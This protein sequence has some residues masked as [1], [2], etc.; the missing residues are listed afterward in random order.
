MVIFSLSWL[1]HSQVEDFQIMVESVR[2]NT[3]ILPFIFFLYIND[4]QHRTICN[5]VVIFDYDSVGFTVDTGIGGPEVVYY[6]IYLIGLEDTTYVG[7][8]SA[9]L[10]D[11]RFKVIV[12][13][14][15]GNTA[16]IYIRKRQL[17]IKKQMEIIVL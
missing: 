17:K 1:S 14:G 2:Y 4:G 12:L 6:T 13:Y 5:V 16:V 11:K 7:E 8:I 9:L 10:H 15:E 3:H